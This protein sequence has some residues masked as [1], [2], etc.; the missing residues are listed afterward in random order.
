MSLNERLGA[1]T[2]TLWARLFEPID[3][4]SLVFF[5]VAFGTLLVVEV[6][7]YFAN[8]WIK[9]FY[10][11]PHFH[12]TYYGFSWVRPLPGNGMYVLFAILGVLGVCIVLG[13]KYRIATPL[14]FLGFAWVFLLDQTRYLNHFY[15]ITLISFLLIFVPA[16]RAFSLDAKFEKG[17][18]ASTVPRWTL[19]ILLA[20]FSLMYIYAG[21]AK[22]NADWLR[23]SPM[24][25]MLSRH[26]SLPWVGPHLT[27]ERVVMVFAYG[28][29]AFD[30]FIVP[31][32]LW[33]RTRW[34]ALLWAAAFHGMNNQ[35]FDIGIFPFFAMAGT[36]L[37]LPPDWPRR[38]WSAVAPATAFLR[39]GAATPSPQKAVAAAAALQTKRARKVIQ[40]QLSRPVVVLLTIYFALQLLLPLRHFL[41]PGNVDWTDEG[42]RFAWRMMLRS[43]Q[44]RGRFV[45]VDRLTGQQRYINPS[46][47]LV[48]DQ[49]SKMWVQP[50]TILQFVH[51]MANRLRGEGWQVVEIRSSIAVSLNGRKAQIFVDPRVN[52]AAQKRNLGRNT[53][54]LPLKEPLPKPGA[55][56]AADTATPSQ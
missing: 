39:G 45:A 33:R 8:G 52:L 50:D 51:Y 12:F 21:I 32:L 47:Y 20:Q 18:R 30:L 2:R 48:R 16:H 36:L 3:I 41:Y 29:L 31:L 49:V 34:F 56:S 6:G 43:K 54:I 27:D 38:L 10:I 5:R 53:W 15:L 28:G 1:A 26:T 11:D 17:V 35:L 4:A 44:G 19:W 42:H 24:R 55:R 7:R 37:Y 25:G 9:Q 14:F 22:I 40:P 46:T 23:G 13:Y